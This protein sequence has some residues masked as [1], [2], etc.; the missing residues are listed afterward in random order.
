MNQI[1][2]AAVAGAFY[3]GESSILTHDVAA[4]LAAAQIHHPATVTAC[5][6]ALI[7]PHAG[8]IYSGP[9]AA[10]AYAQLIPA[11][12]TIRRVVLLG[13]VHR[14]AVRGL[15]LPGNV[16][17]FETPLGIVPLDRKAMDSIA[18]LPLWE[19]DRHFLPLVFDEDPRPFH[20]VMPY[21]DG[22]MQSWKYSR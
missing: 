4:M 19:G 6:K 13:P 7:V 8:Y 22:R 12:A 1:R 11:R 20:G 10:S 5:P 17:S 16:D 21:R 18:D 14:V 9:I 3:P 2:P 15:A